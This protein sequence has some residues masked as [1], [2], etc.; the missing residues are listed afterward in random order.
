M[1]VSQCGIPRPAELMTSTPSLADQIEQTGHAF[2]ADELAHM[3]S[4]SR[5]TIFKQSG[6]H[7]SF[8]IS[9]CV[10]LIPS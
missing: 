5:I 3:L 8:R 9:T 6:T 4:V 1:P 2:M 10:T 7:P